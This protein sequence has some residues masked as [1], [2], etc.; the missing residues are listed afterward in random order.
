[1]AV[2]AQA[3]KVERTRELQR[4]EEYAWQGRQGAGV[5]K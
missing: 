1:M 4:R 2:L 5:S 3:A